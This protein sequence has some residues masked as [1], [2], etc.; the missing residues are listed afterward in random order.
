MKKM[1]VIFFVLGVLFIL[2]SMVLVY[3]KPKV[4]VIDNKEKGNLFE[5]FVI[6]FICKNKSIR[7]VGKVSDYYKNGVMAS[8]NTEPD[9]KFNFYEKKFAVE[10]KWRKEFIDGKINWATDKQIANYNKYQKT[11]DQKVLV[12]I[13]IGGSPDLP[14]KIYFVPL[15]RLTKTLATK[16]Y[17][18]EFEM[19]LNKKFVCQ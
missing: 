14:N 17:I 18:A 12:A 15:F 11:T 6:Q 5:D 8:E 19:D 4:A 7:L 16:N 13:G 1:A 9:L 3:Q 10:C 2:V